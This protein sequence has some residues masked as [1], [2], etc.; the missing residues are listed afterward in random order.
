MNPNRYY[1]L[2]HRAMAICCPVRS[3][4]LELEFRNGPTFRYHDYIIT[5][6]RFNT[7]KNHEGKI[8]SAVYKY[9]TSNPDNNT[10]GRD[11]D[12]MYLYENH[13][14]D[15][16]EAVKTAILRSELLHSEELMR[17]KV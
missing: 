7:S 13:F 2:K 3:T 12:L 11:A 4:I 14:D 1:D 16:G 15:M 17:R 8:S 5:A 9:D 6:W 10:D